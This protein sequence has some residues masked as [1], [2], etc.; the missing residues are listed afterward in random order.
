[1]KLIY[2]IPIFMLLLVEVIA[3]FSKFTAAL[4][5][6]FWLFILIIFLLRKKSDKNLH[7]FYIAL[8]ALPGIR[9]MQFAAPMSMLSYSYQILVIYSTLFIVSLM[10]ARYMKINLFS[11]HKIKS[12]QYLFL[13][14]P[15]AIIAS[16]I[17]AISGNLPILQINYSNILILL[18]ASYTQALFLFGILQ[19]KLQESAGKISIVLIALIPSLFL[20][21]HANLVLITL[22][23]NLIFSY[24]FYKT[25]NLNLILIPEI[26]INS[27][28]FII[29]K[30]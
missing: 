26:I 8:T 30:I 21:A 24:I 6:S 22:L 28:Q 5:Y 18:F 12:L 7:E 14:V 2:I 27:L 15:L 19:N 1:M 20:L 9:I 16:L 11:L 17:G 23:A 4:L 29:F 3:L 13:L 25:K 10:Y